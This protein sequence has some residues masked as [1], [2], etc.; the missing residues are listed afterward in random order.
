MT[1]NHRSQNRDDQCIMAQAQNNLLFF[2]NSNKR[3]AFRISYLDFMKK[4]NDI[5]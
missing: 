3:V 1:F 5:F 2:E 4:Q